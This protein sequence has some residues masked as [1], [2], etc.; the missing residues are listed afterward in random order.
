M[1]R[2]DGGMGLATGRGA[3]FAASALAVWPLLWPLLHVCIRAQPLALMQ[4]K[5]FHLRKSQE[6]GGNYTVRIRL[7][8]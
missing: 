1:H 2:R 4:G 7:L 6:G 8:T 3:S 5:G